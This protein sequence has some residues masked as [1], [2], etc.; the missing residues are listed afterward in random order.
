MPFRGA[1]IFLAQ[2][3]SLRS[4]QATIKALI[5]LIA[6]V[7]CRILR[8]IRN[9]KCGD[10]AASHGEIHSKRASRG[11]SDHR[12]NRIERQAIGVKDGHVQAHVKNDSPL[13]DGDRPAAACWFAPDRKCAQGQT[14]FD[15]RRAS[16]AGRSALVE[17]SAAH[18][19]RPKVGGFRRRRPRA[20]REAIHP[21]AAEG[22]EGS[23]LCYGFVW[24]GSRMGRHPQRSAARR[25]M[26]PL[27]R[28][29]N[30]RR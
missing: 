7:L 26:F 11:C 2:C 1:Q 20:N 17:S 10:G 8:E 5:N 9:D 23:N 19:L 25:N 29:L 27:T 14:R 24:C 3:R 4:I 30:L 15:P 28:G 12:M 16:P 18:R 21:Q 22:H 6:D 13:A